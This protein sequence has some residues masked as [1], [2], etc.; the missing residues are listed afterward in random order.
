MKMIHLMVISALSK[1][2]LTFFSNGRDR[3]LSLPHASFPNIDTVPCIQIYSQSPLG[4]GFGSPSQGLIME[5]AQ[6]SWCSTRK[7]KIPN[8]FK[9]MIFICCVTLVNPSDLLISHL[10]HVINTTNSSHPYLYSM[11]R[12]SVTSCS[13]PF[14]FNSWPKPRFSVENGSFIIITSI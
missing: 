13:K 12:T 9:A 5:K 14:F 8:L 7:Q 2:I 11:L 10:Y 1:Q 4:C 3:D 6:H